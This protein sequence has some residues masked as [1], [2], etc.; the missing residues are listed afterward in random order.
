LVEAETTLTGLRDYYA[1]RTYL[2]RGQVPDA[3]TLDRQIGECQTMIGQLI[4]LN[5]ELLA[6]LRE[7][8]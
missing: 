7:R 8:E 3:A 5:T 1:R 4:R 6:A 2:P